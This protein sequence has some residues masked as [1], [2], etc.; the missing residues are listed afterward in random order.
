[1]SQ[2]SGMTVVDVSVTH[3]PRPGAPRQAASAATDDAAG[4]RRYAERRCT[5]YQLTQNVYSLAPFLEETNGR[6]G[7]PQVALLGKL[8]AEA[9]VAG[10]MSKSACVAMALRQ[11]SVGLSQ[12]SYLLRRPLLVG[13]SAR[14]RSACSGCV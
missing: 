1:V 10:D 9:A 4:A 14:S 3:P 8:G 7:K 13:A 5:N 11:I 2:E 12:G 6:L